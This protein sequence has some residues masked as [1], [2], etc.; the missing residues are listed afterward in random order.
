MVSRGER[1][2]ERI[3]VCERVCLEE[4]AWYNGHKEQVA[5]GRQDQNNFSAVFTHS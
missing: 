4:S 2:K 1:Y 5:S 3:S